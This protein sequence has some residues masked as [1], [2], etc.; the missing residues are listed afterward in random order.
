MDNFVGQHGGQLGFILQLHEQSAIDGDLATG[1]GP[2]IGHRVVQYHKFVGQVGTITD[3]GQ[4]FPHTADIGL[5]FRINDVAA[6]LGLLGRGIVAGTYRHFLLC[7]H[8]REL[9]FASDGVD[10]TAAE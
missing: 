3:G 4:F 5:Y 1:Q 8:Q 6:S 2:G 7:R 10:R 9:A